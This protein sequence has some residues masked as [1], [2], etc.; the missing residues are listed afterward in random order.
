MPLSTLEKEGRYLLVLN[1]YCNSQFQT[2]RAT[3]TVYNINYKTL[4]ACS[5]GQPPRVICL[6]N[7]RKFTTI[8]EKTLED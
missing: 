4:M 2:I 1:A 6:L 5:K 7:G 3:V 8:E